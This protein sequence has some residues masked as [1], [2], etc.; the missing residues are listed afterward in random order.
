MRL[1]GDTPIAKYVVIHI[2]T[3]LAGA[4]IN[5]LEGHFEEWPGWGRIWTFWYNKSQ[6]KGEVEESKSRR[7]MGI[8]SVR[9]AYIGQKDCTH[10]EDECVT[11]E[12]GKYQPTTR[13]D[14]L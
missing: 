1:Q 13:N 4:T 8:F 5:K 2:L 12:K 3:V 14:L 7:L 10:S 11:I 9:R 6:I